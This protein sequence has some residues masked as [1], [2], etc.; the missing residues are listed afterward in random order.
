M[1]TDQ[2]F[3]PLTQYV[4]DIKIL[5][6]DW[7]YGIDSRIVHLVVWVKFAFEEDVVTGD[8]TD[9][10]RKEIE[11]YVDKT[12][13]AQVGPGSCIWFKNW[14]SLKSIHAVEH[15][16]VMLFNPDCGFVKKITNNDV[17]LVDKLSAS[18]GF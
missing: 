15:F 18:D 17:P 1:F 14:A 3:L 2:R 6:N 13:R 4:D 7:P 12:F 8:L 10:A 9:T 5:F 11:T 16:H